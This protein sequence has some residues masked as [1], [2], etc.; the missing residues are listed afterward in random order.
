M[1]KDTSQITVAKLHNENKVALL[2]LRETSKKTFNLCQKSLEHQLI[3]A[4]FLI[5]MIL[6]S[7]S[8]DENPIPPKNNV[9]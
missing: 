1:L 3:N 4:Q 8:N 5:K 7:M 9:N 6:S 2:N